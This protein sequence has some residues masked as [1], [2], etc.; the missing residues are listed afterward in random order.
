MKIQTLTH[1]K[2]NLITLILILFT[3]NVVLITI[4]L[5]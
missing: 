4:V 5:H 1:C 2:S 3:K